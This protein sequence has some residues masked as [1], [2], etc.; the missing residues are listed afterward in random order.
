M[1]KYDES[2]LMLYRICNGPCLA[3]VRWVAAEVLVSFDIEQQ[4]DRKQLTQR[5]SSELILA[6][7]LG[8]VVCGST[9]VQ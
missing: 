7:F 3:F 6:A 2:L 5:I 4:A 8:K 9:P 1:L